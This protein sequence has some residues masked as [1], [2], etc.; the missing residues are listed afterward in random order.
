MTLTPTTQL[1]RTQI[2]HL[3]EASLTEGFNFLARLMEKWESGENRFEKPNERLYQIEVEGEIIGIGGINNDP[4]CNNNKHGRIRH[5]YIHPNHRGK[6][7][8]K[9]IVQT[10]IVDFRGSYEKFTLRTK[11]EKASKFYEAI[12]FMRVYDSETNTHEMLA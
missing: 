5:L 7:L 10:I 11:R 9:K 4:Y 8:G 6:G 1:N 2:T 3:I 12:G